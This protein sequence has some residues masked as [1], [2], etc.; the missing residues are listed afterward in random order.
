MIAGGPRG[1]AAFVLI[2]LASL[3]AGGQ[4]APP[5]FD[6][7]SYAAVVDLVE[8]NYRIEVLHRRILASARD[9]I[10]RDLDPYSRYLDPVEWEWLHRSLAG[11]FGGI[12]VLFEMDAESRRPR[13][14]RLTLGSAAAEAGVVPGDVI[15]EIDGRTTEDMSFDDVVTLL[16]GKPGTRVRIRVLHA[17]SGPSEELTIE[18]RVVRTPSVRAG[19][20]GPEGLWTE[21]VYDGRARIGY[22]RVIR[23]AQDTAAQLERALAA[24][25]SASIRGLVLDLRANEGGLV[26]AATAMADLFL[27]GG[28][29]AFEVG[30][31]GRETLEATPGGYVDVPMAVLINQSSASSTEILA[32]AL[33]DHHRAALF[34]Q[35][36]FGKSLVQELFA[37]GPGAGGLRLSVA[38]Y[39]RASGRNL[40]RF[41]APKGSDEWGVCPDP[42]REIV[43]SRED[44]EKWSKRT[45]DRDGFFQ[46]TSLELATQG[47][48]EEADPVLEAALRW[49]RQCVASAA[50][51][52]P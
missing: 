29:I 9:G 32:S 18:R 4:E 34:G 48:D 2:L 24:L 19:R 23:Q 44:E 30:R 5:I 40:D 39:L 50:P 52:S 14:Q 26:R 49:L 35:R 12:G 51:C 17:A 41:L 8:R 33:Q 43:V 37:L 45:T 1:A 7:I 31:D 38:V 10:L 42:D 13:I 15:L 27:D 36:T 3:S 25:R 11:E 20:R 22:V 28:P 21:Y 46:P 16:P 6:D 47:P